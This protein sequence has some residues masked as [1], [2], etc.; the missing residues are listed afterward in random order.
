LL[1]L[2]R[3]IKTVFDPEQLLNPYRLLDDRPLP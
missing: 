2:Q 3:K 1:E